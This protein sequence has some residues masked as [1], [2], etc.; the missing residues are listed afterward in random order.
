VICPRKAKLPQTLSKCIN[1]L[2]LRNAR[3]ADSSL[4]LA[5]WQT[6]S[7]RLSGCVACTILHELLLKVKHFLDAHAPVDS[8]ITI[9]R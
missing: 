5:R 8:V 4:S 9:E 7:P 3:I 6:L 1:A 2:H